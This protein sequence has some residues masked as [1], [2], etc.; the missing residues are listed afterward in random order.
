MKKMPNEMTDAEFERWL[1]KNKITGLAAFSAS[2]TRK[3]AQ[4]R[5]AEKAR[6]AEQAG[7][8]L[9]EFMRERRDL[10]EAQEALLGSAAP[11]TLTPEARR[12]I[13]T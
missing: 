12:A 3:R 1:K 13:A 10:L 6:E 9:G 5:K 4:A 2:R 11:I 7:K 8:A